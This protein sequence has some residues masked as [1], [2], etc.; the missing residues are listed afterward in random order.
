MKSLETKRAEALARNT[1]R[2]K[3]TPEQQ[4]RHLD[5]VLGL[6]RGAERER[7]RLWADIHA[8]TEKR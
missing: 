6:D 4:I 1:E 5:A 7:A 3:R 2:A 8:H